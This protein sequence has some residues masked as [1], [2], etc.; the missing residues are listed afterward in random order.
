[1]LTKV[2]V[3]NCQ[4]CLTYWVLFS[5]LHRLFVAM[6]QTGTFVEKYFNENLIILVQF[7]AL[8]LN[9]PILLPPVSVCQN[10]GTDPP[11]PPVSEKKIKKRKIIYSP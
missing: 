4:V 5:I 7:F 6:V 2:E 3:Q 1:M 10:F 11:P 8:S 9:S